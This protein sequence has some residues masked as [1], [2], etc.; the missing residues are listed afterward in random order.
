M[1]TR[2]R[3]AAEEEERVVR[4][5]MED[6][7]IEGGAVAPGVPSKPMTEGDLNHW[8]A[9]FF[10]LLVCVV[11]AADS[12]DCCRLLHGCPCTFGSCKICSGD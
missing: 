1:S 9:M 4:P 7:M 2:K 3:N 6:D 10:E 8:N 11:F 12:D 5:K